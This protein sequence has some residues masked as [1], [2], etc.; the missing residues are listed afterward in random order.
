MIRRNEDELRQ[1]ILD[2]D[3]SAQERIES[4]AALGSLKT[5]SAAQTL[6]K[7]GE[8]NGEPSEVLRAA[9][10]EL[11][12]LSHEGVPISEFDMR[13]LVGTTYQAFCDWLP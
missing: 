10:I 12:R 1:V 9:G 6:L 11:A 3:R 13:N 4:I 7:V 2:P 8:R 5:V